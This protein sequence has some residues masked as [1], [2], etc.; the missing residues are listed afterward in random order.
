M[1][2]IA[3]AALGLLPHRQVLHRARAV[4]MCASPLKGNAI[5]PA[6][7]EGLLVRYFYEG[8][9]LQ[10]GRICHFVPASTTAAT[11]L[12]LLRALHTDGVDLRRFFAA[13]Y[14]IEASSGGWFP[15][16]RDVVDVEADARVADVGFP[17]SDSS[18]QRRQ[19]IDVKLFS[20]GA[21]ERD[22]TMATAATQPGGYNMP[23]GGYHAIGVVN[24]KQQAN[25]GTLWR[26]AYQLGASF[27]FTVG[28]RYKNAPTDTIDA[29]KHMPLFEL[30]DW[31][32]FVEHSP[33]GAMWVA[34]E[35]GGTPIEDFV[36]PRNA[37]YLLGSEDAGLP[38]TVLAAC[39]HVVSLSCERYASYN[40]AT[41]GAIVMYD[42]TAKIKAAGGSLSGF[43]VKP[44]DAWYASRRAGASGRHPAAHSRE[45]DS[46]T[47]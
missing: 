5:S 45:S 24:A 18:T 36:H 21:D 44:S 4:A 46:R 30:D 25:I 23:P 39:H 16:L 34:V 26:S 43:S 40:V 38:K 13:V 17:L 6:L 19:R 14:E 1:L 2:L 27:V 41:A 28:A 9:S 12:E 29:H 33:R 11:G 31:N 42:R 35:M 10:H 37:V 7:P 3:I 15:V 32:D 8:A 47:E 22:A 20:R